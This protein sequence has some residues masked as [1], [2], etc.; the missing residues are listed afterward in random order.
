M[1]HVTGVINYHSYAYGK[2]ELISSNELGKSELKRKQ[3]VYVKYYSIDKVLQTRTSR[4]RTLS[5][6]E[7][8]S[9]AYA[10]LKIG[11]VCM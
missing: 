9:A 2:F 8:V 3:T 6:P 4:K 5:G 11:S 1:I 7:K 10:R